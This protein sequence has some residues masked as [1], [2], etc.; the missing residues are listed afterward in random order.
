MRK[1]YLPHLN[2]TLF[3]RKMKVPPEEI[4]NALAWFQSIDENSSAIYL[5]KKEVPGDIAHE[6]I[7][8]LQHICLHRNID[9]I[10][11]TEHMGYLMH[12]LL[13]KVMGYSWR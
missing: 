8:V 13:G 1:I 3:V 2:Y 10:R 6:L 11:E 5:A 7:H 12:Y 4:P 9:F